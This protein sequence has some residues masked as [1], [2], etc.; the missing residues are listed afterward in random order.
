MT[1]GPVAV[2]HGSRCTATDGWQVRDIGV[3]MS[4]GRLI[5]TLGVV[6]AEAGLDP[7]TI[8]DTYVLSVLDPIGTVTYSAATPVDPRVSDDAVHELLTRRSRPTAVRCKVASAPSSATTVS[9]CSTRCGRRPVTGALP[10]AAF[11]PRC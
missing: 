3:A 11:W 7:K 5:A 1:A 6:A 9:C 4:D 10:D 2:G 8:I